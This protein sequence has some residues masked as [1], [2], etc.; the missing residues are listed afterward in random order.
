MKNL[1]DLFVTEI[2]HLEVMATD[3]FNCH[4]TEV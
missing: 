1:S 4:S 2:H 3:F